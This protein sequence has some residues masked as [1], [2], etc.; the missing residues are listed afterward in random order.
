MGRE[1]ILKFIFLI[2]EQ[3]MNVTIFANE[4][5]FPFLLFCIFA[6][7]LIVSPEIKAESNAEGLKIKEVGDNSLN[8]V[9]EL[10]EQNNYWQ[11][12]LD[13]I[14]DRQQL[15]NKLIAIAA[16]NGFYLT[17]SDI[18]DSIQYYTEKSQDNYVC[19]PIGCWRVG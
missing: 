9:Y 10:I 4:I 11:S 15:I 6:Y 7:V 1:S 14:D 3:V 8:G 19:L 12:E 18:E 17:V 5:V 2:S 13:S 16:S